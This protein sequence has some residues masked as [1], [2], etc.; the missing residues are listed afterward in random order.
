[1]TRCTVWNTF[2]EFWEGHG[3]PILHCSLKKKRCAFAQVRRLA[4]YYLRVMDPS[5]FSEDK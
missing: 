5:W 1:M 4:K 3:I 2:D